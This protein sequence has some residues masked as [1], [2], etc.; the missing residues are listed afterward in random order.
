M[1]VVLMVATIKLHRPA[2]KAT[3]LTFG[4]GEDSS[5]LCFEA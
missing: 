5:F 2:A 1:R 4:D 3:M